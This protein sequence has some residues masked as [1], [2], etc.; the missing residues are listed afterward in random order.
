MG[1]TLTM[2]LIISKS[3]FFH[4][5]KLT[6]IDRLFFNVFG[7]HIIKWNL[8]FHK[9]WGIPK[10]KIHTPVGISLFV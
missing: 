3:K 10:N 7:K 5:K 8:S 6:S 2:K 1:I 4:K 9:W